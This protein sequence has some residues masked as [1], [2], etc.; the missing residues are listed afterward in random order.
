[1]VLSIRK[2]LN[3]LKNIFYLTVIFNAVLSGTQ[4]EAGRYTIGWF[5][6]D[7]ILLLLFFGVLNTNLKKNEQ[8]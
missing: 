7:L 3:M 6:V 8:D 1:M 5:M 4:I 2:I